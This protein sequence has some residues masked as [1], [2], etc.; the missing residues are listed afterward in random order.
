MFH[1]QQG[2][3]PGWNLQVPASRQNGDFALAGRL[4]F[5]SRMMNKLPYL[6]FATS[7]VGMAA[8]ATDNGSSTDTPTT[9]T[10]DLAQANGGFTTAD[11]APEF[12]LE[13]DFTA[14]AIEPDGG[15]ANDSMAV[16]PSVTGL[17]SLPSLQV[18]D[19]IVM[20][21]HI[22]AGSGGVERDWSGS[23]TLSRGA[24]V[25]R[26]TVAFE[27]NDHLD[28]PR[29]SPLAVSFTSHTKP[30]SDGLSLRVFD[31]GASTA[32]LTLT[33]QS[34]VDASVSYQID[35]LALDA[36]PI[37]IDAGNGDK[38]VAI[39]LKEAT[40]CDAGFMRGRFRSLLPHLGVYLGYVTGPDGSIIG[41][42][43]GIYGQDKAGDDLIF[44]KFIDLE[45]HFVGLI[46]GTY[47]ATGEFHAK[48]LDKAG[49]HGF[50]H[51]HYFDSPV[52]NGG[53]FVARWAQTS[54]SPDAGS[55]GGSDGSGSA[56]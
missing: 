49:E 30:A 47:D 41:H 36:G 13:A 43:R 20:W 53:F 25:V 39:D 44:G 11:E 4:L 28:L 33:Y 51:G 1:L 2:F 55:G 29:T 50:I 42:V 32:P 9:V 34:S 46:A 7:L 8:C 24:M 48:W 40:V 18:R 15:D 16:D 10:S 5:T 26:R 6:F 52:V 19:V 38:V 21:G 54:C 3:E 23:L 12:G 22:P 31:D 35:L 17:S 56:I 27:L 45:G 37:V 14:A